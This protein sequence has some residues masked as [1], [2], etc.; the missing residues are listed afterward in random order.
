MK[1]PLIHLLLGLVLIAFG[2][3]V[4]ANAATA[5]VA[6]ATFT[7]MMLILGGGLMVAYGF[8]ADSTGNK[9]YVWILGALTLVLGWSFL[10]H[11]LEGVIS[12]TTF[13]LVL[14]VTAGVFQII[15]AVRLKGT[16][17]Y[18]VTLLSGVLSLILGIVVLSSSNATVAFLGVVLGLNLLGSG[19]SLVSMGIFLKEEGV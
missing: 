12:L 19:A 18:W 1:K 3:T 5:A 16:L 15:F 4:L 2:I 13:L 14:L 11:P 10:S 9:I 7:G 6:V 17:G 8:W